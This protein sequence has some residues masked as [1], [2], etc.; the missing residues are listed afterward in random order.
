MDF[1]ARRARLEREAEDRRVLRA[2]RAKLEREAAVLL[3]EQA[4]P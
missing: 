4:E 1:P 3:A 2:H